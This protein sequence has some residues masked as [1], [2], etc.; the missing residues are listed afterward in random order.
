MLEAVVL[1]NVAEPLE[2]ETF[3]EKL[4]ERYGFVIGTK[5]ASANYTGI[6]DQQVKANQRH[7]E[8]RLRTLGLLKR[9]SDDCAFVVNP[10]WASEVTQ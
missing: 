6:N 1:A 5:I 10:F 3:L 7:L 9:L 4:H 2:Y 8:E